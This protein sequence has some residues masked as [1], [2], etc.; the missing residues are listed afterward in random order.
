[1][2]YRGMAEPPSG[3]R[4]AVRRQIDGGRFWHP[5]GLETAKILEQVSGASGIPMIR[6]AIAW[7]L[8]RRWVA[9]VILGVKDLAQLEA[10][11]EGISG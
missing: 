9:S 11:L 1:M 10:N 5:R 4:M 3:T 2:K 6:L 7:P 8:R